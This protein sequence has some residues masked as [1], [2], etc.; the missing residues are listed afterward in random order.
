MEKEDLLKENEGLRKKLNSVIDLNK[1]LT[2]LVAGL[3]KKIKE[4]KK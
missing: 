4:I 3:R 2:M 1:E